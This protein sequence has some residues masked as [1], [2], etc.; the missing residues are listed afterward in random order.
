MSLSSDKTTPIDGII[1]VNCHEK[2]IRYI[3]RGGSV[4][5]CKA[6]GFLL[7]QGTPES[8]TQYH[9]PSFKDYNKDTGWKSVPD[10]TLLVLRE[11]LLPAL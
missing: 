6:C 9:P 2:A 4:L 3:V 1:C 7:T 8:P 5:R 11:T 10:G